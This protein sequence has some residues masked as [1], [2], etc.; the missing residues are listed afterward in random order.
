MNIEEIAKKFSNENNNY[1]GH[2]TSHKKWISVIFSEGLRCSHMKE[3]IYWTTFSLGKGSSTLFENSLEKFNNWEHEQRKQIIIVSYPKEFENFLPDGR[4][5]QQALIEVRE[6]PNEVGYLRPEFILGMYD[7]E[8]GEFQDNPVYYENLDEKEQKKLFDDVKEKYIEI[9]KKDAIRTHSS[10]SSIMTRLKDRGRRIPLTDEE[11]KQID[12]DLPTFDDS[13]IVGILESLEFESSI[14]E[15]ATLS[16]VNA[17][18][19]YVE[20]LVKTGEI[21]QHEG[22]DVGNARDE[23]WD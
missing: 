23:E 5:A 13:E 16:G 1:Y 7:A 20:E 2:G 22:K 9:M 8:I 17:E 15:N 18:T 12:F 3:S 21:M 6:K 10:V 4:V 19:R 14:E 11:I